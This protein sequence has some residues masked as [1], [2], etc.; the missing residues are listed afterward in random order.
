MS[1]S[2]YVSQNATELG[3]VYNDIFCSTLFL[4]LTK[5]SV[6]LPLCTIVSASDYTIY[7]FSMQNGKDFQNLLSVYLDAVFS[8]SLHELDFW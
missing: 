5:F 7:P 3:T 8:L 2:M 4:Y 1:V 6:L